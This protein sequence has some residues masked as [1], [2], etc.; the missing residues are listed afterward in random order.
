ALRCNIVSTHLHEWI[1]LVFEYKQQEQLAI[2]AINV[3]HHLSYEGAIDLD[4]ISDLVERLVTTRIIHNFSQIPCQLFTRSH[5]A[6]PF[7][8][9]NLNNYKFNKHV[10]MLVQSISLFAW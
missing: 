8:T 10:K 9:N 4:T 5:L 7:D 1:D 3:F 2:D 6:R